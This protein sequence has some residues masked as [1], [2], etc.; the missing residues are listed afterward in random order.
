MG[1]VPLTTAACQSVWFICKS[2]SEKLPWEWRY[3]KLLASLS[4]K[5]CLHVC[6]PSSNCS[7]SQGS[8]M[9]YLTNIHSI[10]KASCQ[11]HSGFRSGGAYTACLAFSNSRNYSKPPFSLLKRGIK[12]WLRKCNWYWKGGWGSN[13]LASVY[14]R[15]RMMLMPIAATLAKVVFE[16]Q[17]IYPFSNQLAY[18]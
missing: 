6:V 14:R 8:S 2:R 17:W 11:E 9:L 12:Y 7:I 13:F 16:L 15:V 4:M 1:L 18:F 5:M 10:D 3:H